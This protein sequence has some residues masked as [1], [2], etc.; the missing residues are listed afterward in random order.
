MV[1]YRGHMVYS[2]RGKSWVSHLASK[3]LIYGEE[4]PVGWEMFG[5]AA[6]RKGKWKINWMTKSDHGKGT[7]ELHNLDEDPGENID[8]AEKYGEKV[9]ELANDFDVYV[10]Q[11][12]TVWGLPLDM[13]KPR[14][15]LPADMIGGDPIADQ[16]AWMRVGQGQR[17][18]GEGS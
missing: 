7:W 3:G 16:R 6:L 15:P 4:D 8:L 5:R 1:P 14:T 13:T 18:S 10:K 12:G 17:L 11:T 2:M 9:K